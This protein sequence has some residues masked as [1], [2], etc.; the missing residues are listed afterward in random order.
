[1]AASLTLCIA[2]SGCG[3]PAPK[4][5]GAVMAMPLTVLRQGAPFTYSD[6]A[7]ARRQA[8]ADC[9]ARG[10]SLRPSIHDRYQGGAWVY[11]GG[12]A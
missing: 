1:M 12:C 7:A 10:L 9:A 3:Q 8:E 2:A 4:A 11:P 5:T 6:G